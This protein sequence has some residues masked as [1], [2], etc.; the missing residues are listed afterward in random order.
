MSQRTRIPC[1]HS[2]YGRTYLDW[3]LPKRRDPR[4][5][6]VDPQ[7][8]TEVRNRTVRHGQACPIPQTH[9]NFELPIQGDH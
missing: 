7:A 8:R 6:L 3:V 1:L 4:E 5:L 2:G 9:H